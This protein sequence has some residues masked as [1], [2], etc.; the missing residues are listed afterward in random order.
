MF[1][2]TDQS[3]IDALHRDRTRRLELRR[4]VDQRPSRPLL[5]RRKRQD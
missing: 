3:S 5:R 1:N 4:H 2:F